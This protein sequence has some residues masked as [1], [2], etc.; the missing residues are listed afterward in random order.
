MDFSVPPPGFSLPP[1]G[2]PPPNMENS[3]FNPSDPFYNNESG[4]MMGGFEPTA[5]AQWSVPPP[6][7]TWEP[8]PGHG[9]PGGPPPEGGDSAPGGHSDRWRDREREVSV[10]LH[11]I[12]SLSINDLLSKYLVSIYLFIYSSIHLFI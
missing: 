7:G 3:D 11:I 1:P 8:P 10:C 4:D 2:L 9:P 5:S 12:I 6:A